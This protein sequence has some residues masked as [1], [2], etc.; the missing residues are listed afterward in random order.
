MVEAKQFPTEE[1]EYT[2][3]IDQAYETGAVHIPGFL[4]QE[5]IAKL[6]T[7]FDKLDPRAVRQ[8]TQGYSDLYLMDWA[9]L[10]NRDYND[11]EDIEILHEVARKIETIIRRSGQKYEA[12]REWHADAFSFQ[13][14]LPNS[15]IGP[16][17]DNDAGSVMG[18]NITVQGEADFSIMRQPEEKP[19]DTYRLR[20]GDAVLLRARDLNPSMVPHQEKEIYHS[21]SG[22]LTKEPRLMFGTRQTHENRSWRLWRKQQDIKD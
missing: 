22:A 16:H 12:L 19:L 17:V 9:D 18:V 1:I 3:E 13:K 14:Y 4:G 21:V 15:F 11:R 6:Q 10:L 8:T 2:T 20:P 7:L 5:D